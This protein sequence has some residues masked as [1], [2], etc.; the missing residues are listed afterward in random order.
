MDHDDPVALLPG[1]EPWSH[2][3]GGTTG[4]LV[5][6]GF[7]GSPVSVRNVAEAIAAAGHDVE[8]PRLPGHGT[9]VA[10]ML[11][12]GWHDWIT[13]AQTAFDALTERVER[14]V[15]VGQSMG[16]TLALSTA[17]DR[18][19]ATAAVVCINPLTRSRG[20]DVIEMI[21]DYLE[22]GIT[23]VP[24]EGSDIADPEG[25]DVSYPA[26]PL[27]PL[28][29]LLV[30]GVAPISNR[31]GELTVPLRLFTSRQDHVVEPADSEHLAAAYGGLV[32]H[33]WLERSYHVATRDLDRDIVVAETVAFI[34]RVSR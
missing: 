18:S 22:D 6:H 3:S 4:A 5:L 34:A 1:C 7:T 33:T 26:T 10:D 2:R 8:L 27:A 13:A 17:L 32:E 19:E 21:D 9:T 24:G 16:G 12:T 20:D 14:V 11:R 23:V 31:F 25:V 28:R 30:D 15:V 29:S